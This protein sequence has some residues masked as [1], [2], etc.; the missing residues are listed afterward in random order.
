[1]LRIF[2]LECGE[3][4]LDQATCPA[5]GWR[6]PSADEGVGA[7]AWRVD[8][9]RRLSKPHN[10]PV[11]ARERY[12][13]NTE[14][15]A[16]VALDLESGQTVWERSL[17][18][19]L[20]TH[21]LA[22]DGDR[23]FAG[24]AD[25]RPIPLPGKPF[26]AF[27]TRT[28]DLAWQYPTDAHSLSAAALVDGV[29]YFTS[30]D[31]LLHSVDAATGQKRW[32]V[33]HQAWGPEAPAADAGV[34]CSGGR[35]EALVGYAAADG[36]EAWCLAAKGWFA[37]RPGMA[38][39]RVYALCSDGNLYALEA[40]TGRLLWKCKGERDNGFT[41]DPVVAGGRVFIGSRV[42]RPDGDERRAGYALLALTVEDG[43]EVW[44]FYT[45]RHIFVPPALAGDVLLFA[46]DDGQLYALDAASGAERWRAQMTERIVT[47]PQVA[48]DLV[49]VGERHG[50][51]YA[52]R[53]R[54]EPVEGLL[55]P[56]TYKQRGEYELAAVAH[57]L[58]REFEEAAATYAAAPGRRR[59]AAQLYERAAQQSI[60]A[61]PG[62]E[63]RAA[64]LYERAARL[65]DDLLE[66]QRAAACRRQ[67]RRHRHLPDV[68]VAGEAH[69][70]LVEY[71]WNT[72]TLRVENIG[73]GLARDVTI[74]LRGE[75]DVKGNLHIAG[76]PPKKLVSLEVAMRPHHGQYGPKVPLDIVVLSEDVQGVRYELVQRHPVH[77]VRQGAEPG[78]VTPLG[79]R[80]D[81]RQAP[82][83]PAPPSQDEIDQQ[84][85]LLMTYRRT[86]AH[87]LIQQAA[88]G[89][90]YVPPAVAHG[91]REARDNIQ[92]IKHILRRWGVAAEDG[93]N[94]EPP[95]WEDGK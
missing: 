34:I 73:Y 74:E 54:A 19:G 21:G 71:E 26:L 16:L 8:L 29:L 63:E 95:A 40:S 47:Q 15:G 48:G 89:T 77:V 13:L 66:E 3:L 80:V 44:R 4:I 43:A 32:A 12:C 20:T 53:W 60:A 24:C 52:L 1:M 79:I 10:Y 93:P 51:I 36:A 87:Y 25:V 46:A 45:R 57:A 23:I 65:Y 9:G 68:A 49:Y 27:D 84:R 72:L 85:Q 55:P 94:D 90:G 2:C 30:S 33:A 64:D 69:E 42:Y 75:F 6:R 91:I 37:G 7:E 81:D 56:S 5:C 78:G 35:G 67:V 28:G 41:T 38:G 11:V 86:L 17:G 50:T 88:L 14:D 31:G 39:G 83:R 76:L 59:E 82:G 22:S 18:E 70:A 58:R 92:H 61:A 62:S